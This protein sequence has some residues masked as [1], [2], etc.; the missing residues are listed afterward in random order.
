MD[1]TEFLDS[2]MTK[3]YEDTGGLPYN[4]ED[5]ACDFIRWVENY[6]KPGSDYD[7][8]DFDGVWNSS[9]IKDHPFGRQKAMLDLGLVETFNG[10]KNHPSDDKIIKDAGLTVDIYKERV[11]SLYAQ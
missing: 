6:V 9:S 2:I 7:H 11:N 1:Q 10:M 4:M 5:V 3:V 8:L